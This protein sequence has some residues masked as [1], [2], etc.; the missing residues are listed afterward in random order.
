MM[1]RLKN[2]LVVFGLAAAC[3]AT[4]GAA[5]QNKNYYFPEVK[6]EIRIAVDGSFTVEEERTF[7]YRGRF[8]WASMWLPTRYDRGPLSYRVA[9]EDFDVLD[10]GGGSL[11]TE[12]STPGDRF[13]AKWFYSAA[14][15]RRTFRIRYRVRGAVFSYPDITEIYWQAIGGGWE[16]PT[17]NASVTVHLPA[18]VASKDDLLVY[19]HG[20]LSGAAAILD[21]STARFTATNVKAGQFIEIRMAWPPGLV[22]GVPS[23]QYN[24]ET[25]RREEA[26][27]VQDTV[28]RLEKERETEARRARWL[29]TLT[30]VW[31]GVLLLVPLLWLPFFIRTW[32]RVGQDYH[33]SG[34]PEYFREPASDLPPALV[35]LLM[36]EGVGIT[37]KSFTATVFDLAR[38]G[39]LEIRDRLVEKRHLFR[40]TPDYETTIV[41]KKD[42]RRDS[43]L[44][45]Y[46]ID[47]LD[48]LFEEMSGGPSNVGAKLM[49][50]DLKTYLKRNP[51]KF[52]KW[53]EA[54]SA[55]IKEEGKKLG[56]IEPESLRARNLFAI[57]TV[58]LALLTLNPLLAFLGASLVPT[59]KRRTLTW[60]REYEQWKAFRRFLGDFSNFKDM[61]P[62]AYK[63]WEFYLVFGILFGYAAKI[64][65]TLPVILQNDQAAGPI[66]YANFSQPGF[67][68]SGGLDHMISSINAMSTSIQSAASYSSGSGGGFSGGGGGGAGGGGGG[69]G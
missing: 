65:K 62:E 50:D 12:V 45:V 48:L 30:G 6:I 8:S 20:P 68:S 9:I 58:P 28:A 56:F 57:V 36:K 61:P 38:R 24:R 22:A 1:N 27:F 33:F 60:A 49:V 5:A 37:P 51:Q 66:W 41:L 40:V 35:E 55:S 14:N 43:E 16:K 69:A 34:L 19:G 13:E 29:K 64:L 26:R 59:L 23:T 54:W 10:A 46:E 7:E 39:R 3:L 21:T 44:R 17:R 4:P 15:E 63:L 2:A 31:L 25:I 47:V 42:Y 52:R 67:L 18:P 53:Y 11:R 32:R